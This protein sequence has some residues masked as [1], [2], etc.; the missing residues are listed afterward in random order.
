MF[1]VVATLSNLKESL[2][3]TVYT[4][5]LGKE[6]DPTDSTGSEA[7][8]QERVSRRSESSFRRE[9]NNTTNNQAKHASTAKPK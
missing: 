6:D 2:K 8:L 1:K 7:D 9:N 4:F 3:S 5:T